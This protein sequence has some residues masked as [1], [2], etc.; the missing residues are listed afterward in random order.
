MRPEI[1]QKEIWVICETNDGIVASASYELLGKACELARGK[2][3]KVGAVLLGYQISGYAKDLIAAGAD[4]VYLVDHSELDEYNDYVYSRLISD[5]VKTHRPFIVLMAATVH[6]RAIAPQVAAALKTGLTADCTGLTLDDNG[7]LV[8]T[9]PAF[10]ENL[11][12]EVICPATLPQ[13]ATVRPKTMPMP[14]MDYNRTGEIIFIPYKPKG[15]APLRLLSKKKTGSEFSLSDAE[16]IIAGG[17]GIGSREGFEKLKELANAIGCSVGAS[18]GAVNAQYAD[19]S[20]QIGQTGITVRPK[21][22]IAL[23]ISGAIQHIAGMKASGYVIAVNTDPNASIFDYADYGIVCDYR[24]V[25]DYLASELLSNGRLETS[26]LDQ[27][28]KQ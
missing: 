8:Q 27:A 24:E 10:G 1:A 19:Y 21:L 12:A 16:I 6:G 28:F 15:P 13:M 20:I 9:R 18:R 7:Q 23:G 2:D 17:A 11:M 25:L 3:C 26:R 4:V 22:Y 14:S 5:L